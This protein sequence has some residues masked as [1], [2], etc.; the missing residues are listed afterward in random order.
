MEQVEAIWGL[1]VLLLFQGSSKTF[2]LVV[3]RKYH[4]FCLDFSNNMFEFGTELHTFPFL[5]TCF[6][7]E[8]NCIHLKKG[9]P[10]LTTMFS[11]LIFFLLLKY[12]IKA[13]KF[14]IVCIN[15]KN[16]LHSYPPT[17]NAGVLY[18]SSI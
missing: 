17:Y 13:L 14:L 5:I 9:A 16:G 11:L 1:L 6:N 12:R 10:W 4:T 15:Q 2:L 18:K 3:V 8:L 7:L